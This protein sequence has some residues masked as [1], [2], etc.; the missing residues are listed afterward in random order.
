[1]SLADRVAELRTARILA[2]PSSVPKSLQ[3]PTPGDLVSAEVGRILETFQV[4]SKLMEVREKYW[5]CGDL[6]TVPEGFHLQAGW[7][8]ARSTI[9]PRLKTIPGSPGYH[10]ETWGSG[11]YRYFGPYHPP[12]APK[13]EWVEH[14][15]SWNAPVH[16]SIGVCCVQVQVE[17]GDKEPISEKFPFNLY[18]A[19]EIGDFWLDHT[20]DPTSISLG[21]RGRVS[22][23]DQDRQFGIFTSYSEIDRFQDFLAQYV[24]DAEF[25]KKPLLDYKPKLDKLDLE[26]I[27]IGTGYPDWYTPELRKQLDQLRESRRRPPL[28][29]LPPRL[30]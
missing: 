8:E 27:I 17:K 4:Q 2:E 10:E 19:V 14:V 11:S 13:T 16:H 26:L 1:M 3:T 24:V 7:V 22:Q 21:L 15:E 25:D 30:Y 6:L 23:F 28:K 5:G 9:H 18:L 12:T 29:E 20:I